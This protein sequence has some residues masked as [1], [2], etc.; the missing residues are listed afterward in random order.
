MN[1]LVVVLYLANIGIN[2]TGVVHWLGGS[3]FENALLKLYALIPWMIFEVIVIIGS[4]LHARGK[5]DDYYIN[6]LIICHILTLIGLAFTWLGRQLSFFVLIPPCLS[7]LL[8]GGEIQYPVV[9]YSAI[10]TIILCALIIVLLIICRLIRSRHR[11]LHSH[12]L[13]GTSK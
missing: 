8:A 10:G 2:F 13:V 6:F 12:H 7:I 5:K 4:I 1:T 11:H 3:G 9:Y